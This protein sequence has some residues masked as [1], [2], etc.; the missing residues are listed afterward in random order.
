MSSNITPAVLN[1]EQAAEYLGITKYWLRNNRRSPAAPP[2][3]K[4]GGRV[5]YRVESLDAW[6]SQQEVKY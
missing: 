6:I 1:D 3:L 2:H 5:R 4:I